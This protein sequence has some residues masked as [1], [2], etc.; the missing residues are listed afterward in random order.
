MLMWCQQDDP[1]ELRDNMLAAYAAAGK[2]HA[3]KDKEIDDEGSYEVAYNKA[4]TMIDDG[5]FSAAS[6]ELET[7]EGRILALIE[8]SNC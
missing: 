4:C 3:V 1:T 7:A 2:G 5:N 6:K 8:S